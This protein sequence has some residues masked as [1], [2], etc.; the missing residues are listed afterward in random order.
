M[1]S[2]SSQMQY[3]DAL[4]TKSCSVFFVCCVAAEVSGYKLSRL[5][6]NVAQF[7]VPWPSKVLQNSRILN[8][9]YLMIPSSLS[10]LVR[11]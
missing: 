6:L 9:M 1:T 2:S 10:A 7:L 8:G 3:L 5:V 4:S 11:L